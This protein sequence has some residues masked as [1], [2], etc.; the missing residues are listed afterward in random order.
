M[1]ITKLYRQ[2]KDMVDAQGNPVLVTSGQSVKQVVTYHAKFTESV[3]PKGKTV[4]KGTGP[5]VE[6]TATPIPIGDGAYVDPDQLTDGEFESIQKANF[7]RKTNRRCTQLNK[8][9]RSVEN[10]LLDKN[11]L[12]TPEIAKQII[13]TCQLNIDK[14]AQAAAKRLTGNSGK[15]KAKKTDE[16]KYGMFHSLDI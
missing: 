12:L 7:M 6:V 9:F 8:A 2:S 3:T 13:A 14:I 10:A 1:A 5:A 11:S 16:E 15:A 4:R